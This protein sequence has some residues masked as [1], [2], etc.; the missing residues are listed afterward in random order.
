MDTK[1]IKKY[2]IDFT[3]I[4]VK[5]ILYFFKSKI[6]GK[7]GRNYI[8]RC[9]KSPNYFLKAIND[10]KKDIMGAINVNVLVG[11]NEFS[12]F[13]INGREFDFMD[14]LYDL[15]LSMYGN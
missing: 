8:E 14:N 11:E 5:N 1:C 12:Y 4:R 10:T 9:W 15:G 3:N 13:R 2:I 7:H 6:V